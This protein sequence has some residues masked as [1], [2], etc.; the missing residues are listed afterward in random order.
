MAFRKLDDHLSVSP[1]LTVQQVEEAARLGFKTIIDNRPDGEEPGQPAAAEIEAAARRHG[2]EFAHI[3]V[4]SGNI[5]PDAP[6]RMAETLSARPSPALAYC[7]TGTRS[8]TLWALG[9]AGSSPADDLI[10]AAGEAGY[11]IE[12]L[13]PILQ[14]DSQ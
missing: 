8:T 4:A 7:R 11:D 6:R 1:Q 3:P 9:Q 14:G 12:K 5:A 13:R 10:R 2:L